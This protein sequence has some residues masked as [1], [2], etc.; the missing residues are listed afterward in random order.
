MRHKRFTLENDRICEYGKPISNER[1]VTV[2]NEAEFVYEDLTYA[3][4]RI[5]NL[6]GSLYHFRSRCRKLENGIKDSVGGYSD[7]KEFAKK[8]RII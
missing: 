3:E 2:L 6:K 7:L 1:I 4:N 8:M 5:T